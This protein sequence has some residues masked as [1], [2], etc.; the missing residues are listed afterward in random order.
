[1][2]CHLLPILRLKLLIPL[3]ALLL[4]ACNQLATPLAGDYRAYVELSGG[5]VPFTLKIDDNAQLWLVQNG[6]A[7]AASQLKLVQGSFTATLPNG[8]GTLQA[9]IGR[10]KLQGELR[11]PTQGKAQVLPFTAELNKS[12]RFIE[13]VSTDNA[14]VSGQWQLHAISPAHFSTAVTLELL[15][16]HDAIDGQLLLPDGKKVFVYGQAH[17]D[18][19]YLSCLGQGTAML[20]KGNVNTKG[21]LQ[22]KLWIN[23][24]EAHAAVA[25][26]MQEKPIEED[27]LR[28]VALPWEVPTR[29]QNSA[30]E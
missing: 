25:A 21:E 2:K 7:Q 5:A 24:S 11:L 28:Q 30:L 14:D 23:L 1:M 8:V 17:G 27:T 18:D 22:G 13:K 26:R 19:I 6:E 29:S 10:N 12:Y 9:N 20:F 15:Q 3:C 16:K 4:S